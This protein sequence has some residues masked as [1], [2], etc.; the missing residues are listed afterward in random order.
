MTEK[1]KQT[2]VKAFADACK[3]RDKVIAKE[4]AIDD[5]LRKY[6]AGRAW[7]N[8][9]IWQPNQADCFETALAKDLKGVPHH[10]GLAS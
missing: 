8:E 5:I 1:D 4:K 3:F 6:G 7:L 9:A 10:D 2:I